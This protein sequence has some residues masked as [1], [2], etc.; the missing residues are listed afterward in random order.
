MR[1]AV[2][3][4]LIGVLM[5]YAWRSDIRRKTYDLNQCHTEQSR[6]SEDSYTATYCYGPGEN[7]VLR[8]YRTNN[9]GLV[10]ERLFTF[11]RDEPVRLTWD[12]DA[13]VYDTAATDGEGMIA[14]P[15]SLSDRWLAMLP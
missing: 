6:L 13:I 10:A 14:L 3:L 7:V 15:P 8:L 4:A 9:M 5:P 12:R 1:I 11:P 2:T